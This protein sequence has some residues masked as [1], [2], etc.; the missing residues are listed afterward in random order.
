MVRL[1]TCVACV[2]MIAVLITAQVAHASRASSLFI[3]VSEEAEPPFSSRF[4]STSS[5]VSVT[6]DD[7]KTELQ[8]HAALTPDLVEDD[9]GS[10]G[11][12]PYFGGGDRSPIPH[13]DSGA[14]VSGS[15]LKV[16][17]SAQWSS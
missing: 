6:L 13:S 11:P 16:Q 8:N 5:Q 17:S 12:T 14:P 4:S 7:E 2:M 9:Y 1:V 10:W 15:G 3:S